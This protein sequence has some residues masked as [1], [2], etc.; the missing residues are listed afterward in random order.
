MRGSSHGG[1]AEGVGDAFACQALSI[2]IIAAQCMLT[3]YSVTGFRFK[4][5]E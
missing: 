3:L 2:C 4:E 1:R 5:V